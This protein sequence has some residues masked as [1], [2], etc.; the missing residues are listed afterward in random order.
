MNEYVIVLKISMRLSKRSCC[1]TFPG[2]NDWKIRKIRAKGSLQRDLCKEIFAVIPT[3]LSK[4]FDSIPHDHLLAK[5]GADGFNQKAVTLSLP[6]WIVVAKDQQFAHSSDSADIIS[7]VSKGSV[8]G[9]VLFHIQTC[10][11]FVVHNFT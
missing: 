2:S 3:D 6:I 10:D 1:T 5:L 8:A 11:L 9:P 7:S 4:A